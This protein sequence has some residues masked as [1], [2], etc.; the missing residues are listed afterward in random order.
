MKPANK[1]RLNTFLL[2][3]PKWNQ[4]VPNYRTGANWFTFVIYSKT[5]AIAPKL[6]NGAQWTP[7]Q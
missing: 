4:L 7:N 1:N 6:H 2:A 3:S 5:G